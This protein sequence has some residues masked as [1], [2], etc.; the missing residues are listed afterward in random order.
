MATD[1][2]GAPTPLGIPKYNTSADAPSGLGFNAAMDAVDALIAGRIPKSLVTTTGDMIYA[3]GASTPARLPIGS[4][5]Q[6]LTVSG[7]VPVWA[8]AASSG[9]TV[10]T[11]VAGLGTGADGKLGLLRTG[12]SPY[13]FT[14]LVYDATYGKWVSAETTQ[15]VSSVAVAQAAADTGITILQNTAGVENFM[16]AGYIPHKPYTDAGLTLQARLAFRLVNDAGTLTFKLHGYP[17]ADGDTTLGTDS[18][19]TVFNTLTLTTK[20]VKDS[21][22]VAAA[23]PA[24]PKALLLLAIGLTQS[25]NAN[26]I[27]VLSLQT[28]WIA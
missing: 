22:W 11:T 14:A 17:Q 10:A 21:G 1:A 9:A 24:T 2:T 25:V 12:S 8:A 26:T 3:S 20:T 23:V 6:I 27:G 15:W 13:D 7:G 5:N 19:V 18:N 4:S 16:Y 28:R